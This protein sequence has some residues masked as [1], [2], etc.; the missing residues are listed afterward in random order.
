MTF[1]LL[2][3]LICFFVVDSVALADQPKDYFALKQQLW[4]EWEKVRPNYKTPAQQ[5]AGL[6]KYVTD[7]LAR[8]DKGRISDFKKVC[9]E[10]GIPIDD[11]LFSAGS[12]PGS[13]NFKP[14]GDLDVMARDPQAYYRFN[15]AAKKY[16]LKVTGN[17]NSISIESH[18]VT[19]HLPASRYSNPTS[20]A[21]RMKAMANDMEAAE[22][23]ALMPGTSIPHGKGTIAV[24]SGILR[25]PIVPVGDFYKK[26]HEANHFLK[27]P[28]NRQ[29]VIESLNFSNKAV[30]KTSQALREA[31]I[32]PGMSIHRKNLTDLDQ[33]LG[34]RKG[35][36]AID[37]A[38]Q[39]SR[40]AFQRMAKL[41]E[42]AV[43]R[44]ASDIA[45]VK[46][47]ITALEKAGDFRKA[48]AL[49]HQLNTTRNQIQRVAKMSGRKDLVGRIMGESEDLVDAAS[50]RRGA[51]FLKKLSKKFEKITPGLKQLGTKLVKVAVWAGRLAQLY[52][53]SEMYKRAEQHE[54]EYAK[55]VGRDPST[56][57]IAKEFL[58]EAL[59]FHQSKREADEAMR[60]MGKDPDEMLSW[61]YMSR[62]VMSEVDYLVKAYNPLLHL[63][64][65]DRFNEYLR[66]NPDAAKQLLGI[67]KAVVHKPLA[68]TPGD[69]PLMV[70]ASI[71]AKE[72]Q[73]AKG[74]QHAEPNLPPMIAA[75]MNKNKLKDKKVEE[76]APPPMVKASR[77]EKPKRKTKPG[78]KPEEEKVY[79]GFDAGKSYT[80]KAIALDLESKVC[81]TGQSSSTT[82]KRVVPGSEMT[83][84]VNQ[85][86]SDHVI[87][88]NQAKNI[89]RKKGYIKNQKNCGYV[90]TKL[91]KQF[92]PGITQGG[93]EGAKMSEPECI[94][95]FCS[96]C[97]EGA[98]LI[99]GYRETYSEDEYGLPSDNF[100]ADCLDA[101]RA[102]IQ[103]CAGWG[104]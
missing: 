45:N 28:Y 82:F 21:N 23:Y 88:G 6:K 1:R 104:K 85:Q 75:S 89:L 68:V 7:P 103:A 65:V 98:I 42:L 60:R 47:Q 34:D 24:D 72:K 48:M 17:G 102:K 43:T 26:A 18:E 20:A 84:I 55:M 86:G 59:G 95:K 32:N 56:G 49:R 94:E 58:F 67:G 53:V 29:K 36:D 90:T 51:E 80:I 5:A 46:R 44:S 91:Y 74:D 87:S 9:E 4:S 92:G 8:M 63:S 52:E 100:C 12:P 83:V 54:A 41:R 73:D 69:V 77:D 38:H 13:P 70:A 31:G 97:S 66:E 27:G 57:G 101:N 11:E 62:F 37:F 25:T 99:V 16:G 81:K 79:T 39:Y 22:G 64:P 76:D 10:A 33:L 30:Y 14:G 40:R 35:Q 2:V 96:G 78:K 50:G 93:N 3:V 15:K 71:K 61:D 19:M